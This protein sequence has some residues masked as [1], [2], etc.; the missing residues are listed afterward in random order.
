MGNR[1][2]RKLRKAGWLITNLTPL[3][4]ICTIHPRLTKRGVTATQIVKSL[5]KKGIYAKAA[6][7]RLNEPDSVRLGIISR[8]TK[9]EDVDYVV[10]QLES[11]V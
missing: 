5:A 4:V 9:D 7:L 3:P 8:R 1:L 6:S 11:L 10:S 2:R